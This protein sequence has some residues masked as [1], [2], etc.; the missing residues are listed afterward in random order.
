MKVA[1]NFDGSK[2]AISDDYLCKVSVYDYDK[3]NNSW[4]LETEL[5]SG[6]SLASNG[7]GV[8]MSMDWD[9]ERIVV[10]ANTISNVYTFDYVNSAWSTTPRVIEGTSGSDFGFSVSMAANDTD[11]LCVGAPLENK[12]YV[13]QNIQGNWNQTYVNDGT[14]ILSRIPLTPTS[15]I[16]LKPEYNAYGYHVYMEPEGNYFIAS[17]P[18]QNM[19]NIFTSNILSIETNG[20]FSDPQPGLDYPFDVSGTANGVPP[21]SM[22][23]VGNIRVFGINDAN[24]WEKIGDDL[25]GDPGNYILEDGH[26]GYIGYNNYIGWSMPGFGTCTHISNELIITV[27]SPGYPLGSQYGFYSGKISRFKFSTDVGGWIPYGLDS[28]SRFE[29]ALYGETFTMDYV[30]VR[31]AIGLQTPFLGDLKNQQLLTGRVYVLEWN[32]D[33]WHESQEIILLE[34]TGLINP[35]GFDR[36]QPTIVNGKN[37]FCTSVRRGKM[38]TKDFELTQIFQGNSLF[39]GYISSGIIKVGDNNGDPTNSSDK[40]ILF[41]GTRGDQSYEY[42]SIENRSLL[43]DGKSE[44]LHSKRSPG[45]DQ[46]DIIRLKANEIHLDNHS[47]GTVLTRVLDDPQNKYITQSDDLKETHRPSLMV[48]WR[49]DVCVMP[50]INQDLSIPRTWYG[51]ETSSAPGWNPGSCDSKAALDV[52]GD[53]FIRNRMNINDFD[54]NRINGARI[55]QPNIFY[56][57]RNLDVLYRDPNQSSRILVR[58]VTRPFEDTL[59]NLF[60]VVEGTVNYSENYRGFE[61]IGNGKITNVLQ[62]LAAVGSTTR[63]SFWIL[64]Q[65]EQSTYTTSNIFSVAS[66]ELYRD[67][68]TSVTFQMTTSGFKFLYEDLK[69]EEPSFYFSCDVSLQKDTWYNIQIQLMSGRGV[70]PQVTDDTLNDSYIGIWIDT[71]SVP[72]TLNGVAFEN[73]QGFKDQNY[74]VGG[75]TENI[76]IGMIMFYVVYPFSDTTVPSDDPKLQSI[77]NAYAYGPPPEMLAVGGDATISGKL[78]VGVTNPT[79][80]LEV[81]GNV[82]ANYF[83]GD[84]SELSNIT[85]Q[86]VTDY[87][88]V[89][90]NTVQ[91]TNTGTSLVTSGKVG[92]GTN[93]TEALDIDGIIQSTGRHELNVDNPGDMIAKRYNPGDR[94]GL[95][96]YNN[97]VTR[98]F[99]S[100]TFGTAS[101]RFSSPTND[102]RDGSAAFNDLMTVKNNGDVG[103]GT[104]NPQYTL[105]VSGDVNF[106]GNLLKNGTLVSTGGLDPIVSLGPWIDDAS[107]L[108]LHHSNLNGFANYALRQDDSGGTHIN[109]DFSAL[110]LEYGGTERMRVHSNGNVGVNNT[111]PVYTLDVGG[112]IRA[113]GDVIAFSDGRYKTDVYRI[114]DALNKINRVSGYTYRMKEGTERRAGVIAQEIREVLPEVVVGTEESGYN[115]AY[116]NMAGLFIEAIKELT[117]QVDELKAK[118]K[119]LQ[120][121]AA[122]RSPECTTPK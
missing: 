27:S 116:G 1:A 64:L 77:Q 3:L 94:Y 26:S 59:V 122:T 70:V 6:V 114:N 53:V 62:G 108:V 35:N 81:T 44:I 38:H 20:V 111:G 121:A 42:T 120:A 80:A 102:I 87:G 17:A 10:G 84:G 65:N 96:Q 60:G 45:L 83:M 22:K 31:I 61:F 34:D 55:T 40:K 76:I 98:V 112:T 110:F 43:R 32:E 2:V 25:E 113:S 88:N 14:S 107:E 36:V 63:H 47:V 5:T 46:I 50:H 19:S 39:T 74:I 21:K 66:G 4:T 24:S 75:N 85:L 101:I 86:T 104:T 97:G 51:S 78:G 106:T 71:V 15:N 95:G 52:N 117:T 67:Q 69:E 23:H 30:G 119:E 109:A 92:V 8:S 73:F 105:D 93:P 89:T 11:I 58:S 9:A 54:K 29:G 13:Y 82:H 12:V 48:N 115:V 103:I 16:I 118:V 28:I 41:G 49:G 57:T 7:F 91:F 72:L 37:V 90:S 33:T 79:E 68:A 56:N 100:S 99:T 18:G